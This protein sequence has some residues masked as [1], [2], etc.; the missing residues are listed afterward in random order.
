MI[1]GHCDMAG[2]VAVP[3]LTT[4][5]LVFIVGPV[6]L[7]VNYLDGCSGGTS[8]IHGHCD[9]YGFVF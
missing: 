6:F 4:V 2:L 7:A 1:Q 3:T 9:P 5:I 8:M